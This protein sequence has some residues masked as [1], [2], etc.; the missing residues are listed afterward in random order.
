MT[1]IDYAT[2]NVLASNVPVAPVAGRPDTGTANKIVTL[3]TGQ[4]GAEAYVIK[5]VMTG[6]YTN[7]NQPTGEK[8]ATVV[9]MKPAVQNSI[10]GGGTIAKSLSAAG[11]YGAISTNDPVAF[12]IGLTYNK[13]LTNI[14]G[15]ATLTVMQTDGSIL[16]I[17]TTAMSSMSVVTS[18]TAKTATVYSKGN[19]TRIDQFGVS[20]S[21]DGN[22]SFR[23]DVVDYLAATAT[24]QIGFTVLSSKNSTLQYSNSWE[25]VGSGATAV[26]KTVTKN[27]TTGSISVQ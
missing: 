12:S 6:N 21:L 27:I 2:G 14:Q 25:L 23:I 19:V 3:S 20:T 11:T 1:F 7:V 5:V 24:D 17:K 4:Y 8:T 15:K 16:F 22:A 9:V 26:W 13:A 18:T 10:M